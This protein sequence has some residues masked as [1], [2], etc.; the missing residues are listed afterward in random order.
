M[1]TTVYLIRH[2]QTEWNV[3][4]RMQGQSDSPLTP[5]GIQMAEH[6]APTLPRFGKIISSP[7]G[8]TLHT[9]RILF[10]DQEIVC[11]ERLQEIN[12]GRWEG[13]LQSD[14]DL[15]EPELHTKFW[16]A[17][18]QFESPGGESYLQVADRSVACFNELVEKYPGECIA[19]VSHTLIVRSI[20][21][22]IES[23]ELSAFWDPPA[24]YP[25]SVSEVE[26]V[27]GVARVVRFGCTAHH[28]HAH[29]GA[30]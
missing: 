19:L 22:S 15:D 30:Y 26:I 10:G 8:R 2:G 11:D 6:L 13:L 1:K 9:A 27:D 14:L 28:D 12:L 24:I 21:F 3:E 4:R 5:L 20:L 23:R 18:H 29:E 17:P 16:K 25:A 7:S